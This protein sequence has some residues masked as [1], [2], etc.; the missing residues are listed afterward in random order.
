MITHEYNHQPSAKRTLTIPFYLAVSVVLVFCGMLSAA[1]IVL[2]TTSNLEQSPRSVLNE[3]AS[4]KGWIP[5]RDVRIRSALGK[6]PGRYLGSLAPAPDL[7][8]LV[9]DIPFR[10]Q[11]IL[12]AKREEALALG[13]L[14]QQDG[15]MVSAEIRIDDRQVPVRLRLKGDQPDHYDSDKWS[16]RIEV[17]GDDHVLGMRRFSLQ[18]PKVRR[19]QA[20][21]L[22]METLGY[23]DVLRVRYEFVNVV[24]NGEDKGIMAL[25][26]HFSKELL[27]SQARREGVIVRFDESNFWDYQRAGGAWR[28]SPYDSYR[29]S[30]VRTFGAGAI[31][32]SP[33]LSAQYASAVGMLRSF[34]YDRVPASDVFDI[35]ATA[36]YLAALELWGSWQSIQ[37]ND[38]RFYLDPLTMKL[39]P[40][41][42]DAG[43]RLHSDVRAITLGR[44]PIY[45][46]M[47][48][49][50]AIRAAFLGKLR[51]LCH[52]VLNGE[53]G[54]K[55]ARLQDEYLQLLRHEYLLLEPMDLELL[56]ERAAF[57]LE[58][59]DA[60]LLREPETYPRRILYPALV[61]AN[62]IEEQGSTY[63][64]LANHL[65]E[66]V[67]VKSIEW[68]DIE[69]GARVPAAMSA[70]MGLPFEIAPTMVGRI[71]EFVRLDLDAPADN[72]VRELVVVASY[73]NWPQDRD[74]VA[75]R[76]FPLL[77]DSPVPE[78]TLQ[79]QLQVHQFLEAGQGEKSLAIKPGRWSVARDIVVPEGV[80]LSAGAGTVL[81]FAPGTAII[82]RG[83]V[84]FN[85]SEDEPIVLRPSGT[86]PWQGIAV[87]RA[88]AKSVL[89]H[90]DI[91]NTNGVA[92][93]SWEMAGGTNF[94]HSDVDFEDV[95]I[96][97]HQGQDALNIVR[98]HF[99]I[100][101]LAITD[102]KYDG[103]DG[104]FTTGTIR[105]SIFVSVGPNAGGGDAIDVSGSDVVVENVRF[106]RV[107]DKALSVGEGSKMK[108][109]NVHILS[110]GTAAASKD[111]SYLELSGMV[112]D[113][114]TFAGLMAYI[115]KP[116]YGKAASIKAE[117]VT[118]KPA[119]PVGRVQNGNT[120]ELDGEM[121][122]T[123]DLDVDLLYETVMRKGS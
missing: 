63:L 77:T 6:L 23:N 106:D 86:E 69:S 93:G 72:A 19:Y 56:E 25:E 121:L 101:R 76:Y 73:E 27:E 85:G 92:R 98:S 71:P 40:I 51:A 44:E 104:D 103:F 21:P 58:L 42:Y 22:F 105:D 52:D 109:S 112:V 113:N 102:A 46:A 37:W 3:W 116:E 65:P 1:A 12:R 28:S 123:E 119:G 115:K 16:M 26:E 50:P 24:V 36:A 2:S 20:E 15:D 74:I 13:V 79:E 30:R 91:E 120:I 41:G 60:E 8:T 94:Y 62:L 4:N 38:M 5:E 14:I 83:P 88:G 45:A 75:V 32:E 34:A 43:L 29:N 100:S 97:R 107:G 87:L 47:L 11:E 7:P 33:A 80:T 48:A 57:L 81:E 110:A 67:T 49:D 9:V 90:V 54:G 78:S 95:S 84:M 59:S 118:F 82:S 39:E 66:P 61:Q 35:D 68:R 18:H 17:R 53:L 89:R 117:N 99:D 55:L 122:P 31:A 64:E 111:G 70:A 108:A 10:N 114:V 96:T